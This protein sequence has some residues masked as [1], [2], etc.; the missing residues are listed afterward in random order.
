MLFQQIAMR[1][2]L[3]E[4]LCVS[5]D[6][7]PTGLDFTM[8]WSMRLNCRSEKHGGKE[9]KDKSEKG[10]STRIDWKLRQY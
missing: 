10:P 3:S 1:A 9:D 4:W 6:R 8:T 2:M 5:K 7:V